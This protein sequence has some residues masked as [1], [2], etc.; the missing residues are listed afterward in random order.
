MVPLNEVFVRG[1][2]S[3]FFCRQGVSLVLMIFSDLIVSLVQL[4]QE[5]EKDLAMSCHHMHIR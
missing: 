2:G 5:L 1:E 4:L 3:V